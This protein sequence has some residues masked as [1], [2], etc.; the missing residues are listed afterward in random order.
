M[1]CHFLVSIVFYLLA[2]KTFLA[3]VP[4]CAQVT[5]LQRQ[6]VKAK[7]GRLGPIRRIKLPPLSRKP[8]AIATEQ[9]E[10]LQKGLPESELGRPPAVQPIIR[11]P[12][13]PRFRGQVTRPSVQVR[14]TVL[15]P[16]A[17]VNPAIP[18]S[19][20]DLLTFRDTSVTGANTEEPNS[21][22]LIGTRE[23]S[24]ANIGN[25]VF[26]T[27][28]AFAAVSADGGATFGF[29]DP[30]RAFGDSNIQLFA[31]QSAIYSATAN[32][33]FWGILYNHGISGS[34]A[35]WVRI[36]WATGQD[37]V[38]N[39]TWKYI[40]ITPQSLQLPSRKCLD[41]PQ[42]ALSTGYLY[43]TVSTTDF[44]TLCH[45]I[46]GAVA[47]RIPLESLRS[48]TGSQFAYITESS[49]TAVFTPIAGAASVMYWATDVNPLTLRLYSW[50]DAADAVGFADVQHTPFLWEDS[51]Q[52]ACP[53]SDG[54]DMCS[55]DDPRIKTGWIAGGRIGFL[56]DVAQG[57]AGPASFGMFPY[58]YVQGVEIDETTW[59]VVSEP[60][61][62]S[63]RNAWAFPSVGVNG[64]GHLGM[65]I[66]HGGGD[67][68]PGSDLFVRDDI[69]GSD[70]DYL[71]VRFGT[72]G[73][74][75]SLLRWG[76]FLS[77]RPSSGKD[78]SWVGTGFTF[79]GSDQNVFS[80][81]RFYWFGR[82]RDAPPP[83]LV[84]TPT[85]VVAGGAVTGAWTGVTNP[86]VRDWMGL[87]VHD[88][89][90]NSTFVW[91]R[92]TG[93]SDGSNLLQI[94]PATP[95]GIY[96]LRLY[97]GDTFSL[98]ARSNTFRVA[99]SGPSVVVFPTAI[100]P[101]GS[102]T[103][104]WRGIPASGE[105]GIITA[106]V[107]TPN[108]SGAGVGNTRGAASGS[109]LSSAPSDLG[110]YD[111]RLVAP[112]VEFARS[113]SFH[114]EL[115]GCTP[116][117]VRPS[118]TIVQSRA[119]FT[120]FWDHICN[121]TPANRV[122]LYA[123]GEAN[124]NPIATGTTD[125][126]VFGSM[127]LVAPPPGTYELRLFADESFTLLAASPPFNAAAC[128]EGSQTRL[129]PSVP[130]VPLGG[131]LTVSWFC[132]ATPTSLDW[133]GLF[134]LDGP[135]IAP[136]A[137]LNTAGEATGNTAFSIP[138]FL[139]PGT[140]N[141]RLFINNTFSRI[142]F[143]HAFTVS[144]SFAPLLG[145][146]PTN[147]PAG[148]NTTAFWSGIANPSIKDWLGL[149]TAGLADSS[150]LMR[151]NT[152]GMTSGSIP[153]GIPITLASG[154]Y[155][156]RLFSDDVI[157]HIA[158]SNPL[159]VTAP[160]L[161]TTPTRIPIGGTVTAFWSGV[162]RATS[163]DWLGL[164]TPAAADATPIVRGFT[165]GTVS[166]SVPFVLPTTLSPGS[167]QLR[168]FTNDTF[169]RLA[170]GNTFNVVAA[171][172]TVS[173]GGVEPGQTVTATW[174]DIGRPSNTDWLGL[175]ASGSQ[176]NTPVVRMYTNGSANGSITF[177]IPSS[178]MPGR[179][180]LRLFS[181]DTFTL[182][183]TSNPF[184]VLFRP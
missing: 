20:T 82:Q 174:S 21:E 24:A 6:S 29:I 51:G 66:A 161:Q 117:R 162:G 119:L 23:P 163:S 71:T 167:F 90:T 123:L 19:T 16:P 142:T 58:P 159:S 102:F 100:A 15:P 173:P 164:Y 151:I 105:A 172:L 14:R 101:R 13:T 9:R 46:D 156:L 54:S 141:F 116:A 37:D 32:I 55:A 10:R 62:W 17:S 147:L 56:W 73:P 97:A 47:L 31:D 50:P 88:S 104:N 168:L 131:T 176:D 166:G 18:V 26:Y 69:S 41:Y 146:S 70:W 35:G 107:G 171:S 175:Y 114:V 57:Y 1:K 133:I 153:F 36:A 135:D 33:L 108:S 2:T 94:P 152:T 3:C 80:E 183:A 134:P 34:A 165:S 109:L 139:A 143:S 75:S 158:I 184:F 103:V 121:P 145:V 113:N 127:L 178:V 28:N 154:F 93:A 40:D 8:P 149:Y 72:E 30:A 83:M 11:A 180:E 44:A 79:Q 49:S 120:A 42:L 38:I 150:P 122:G 87:F 137:R 118:G 148:A 115:P 179:Y 96:E 132:V 63:D 130:T 68:F 7:Y 126:L 60:I 92:T 74:H 95:G 110:T 76:D 98:L 86:S 136:V 64:R 78:N 155:E 48:G 43:V 128:V 12:L 25:I 91:T 140:Y 157:T 111:L 5:S 170:V 77:V 27:A 53:S 84:E 169:V 81:T 99:S 160:I 65:S 4:M 125:G 61:I 39:G 129:V 89:P 182:L 22:G 112:G 144:R 85:T 52:R 181:N 124:S 177:L 59:S 106:P 67:Y 45:G 138:S